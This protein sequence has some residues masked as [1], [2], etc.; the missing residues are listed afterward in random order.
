MISSDTFGGN[1]KDSDYANIYEKATLYCP[2]PE[3]YKTTEAWSNFNKILP[4]DGNETIIKGIETTSNTNASIYN[5]QG[6]KLNNLQK[7]INIVG[8]KKVYVK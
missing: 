7:G 2:N 8:K 5:L 3:L 6:Q 1:S 4:L